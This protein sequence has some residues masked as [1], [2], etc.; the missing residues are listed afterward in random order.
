MAAPPLPSGICGV[1]DGHGADLNHSAK[2]VIDVN[3]KHCAL[4]GDIRAQMGGKDGDTQFWGAGEDRSLRL[5]WCRSLLVH[6][7]VCT[8]SANGF[9]YKTAAC[10]RIR[11]FRA[12]FPHKFWASHMRSTKL[13]TK[14]E[15]CLI[16]FQ[17][18]F[19]KDESAWLYFWGLS[20]SSPFTLKT[21][22]G[23]E[24]YGLSFNKTHLHYSGVFSK[25][26]K[27]Q[28]LL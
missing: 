18:Q 21:K 8:G 20:I 26:R 12:V 11:V 17:E 5:C 3:P 4:P 19:Y 9:R 16:Q 10:C 23:E 27:T 7:P 22:D 13:S 6:I 15:N 1:I 24:V 28:S 25:H 14:C 2:P